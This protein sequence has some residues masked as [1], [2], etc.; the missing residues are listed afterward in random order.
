MALQEEVPDE[1]DMPYVIIIEPLEP[2]Q[3]GASLTVHDIRVSCRFLGLPQLYNTMD[4]QFF[5][6]YTV[7]TFPSIFS[8]CFGVS[9]WWTH[10]VLIVCHVPQ[11]LIVVTQVQEVAV[12]EHR[13]S[14]VIRQIRSQESSE[15]EVGALDVPSFA[16]V[17]FPVPQLLPFDGSNF[18]GHGG[19]LQKGV[20]FNL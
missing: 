16:P 12:Q 3:V 20:L 1:G 5:L 6:G 13:P 4:D 17:Q 18:D 14:L 10:I 9:S 11:L 2:V 19:S 8:V 15:W 7:C